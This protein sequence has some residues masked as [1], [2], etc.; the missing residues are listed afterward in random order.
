MKYFNSLPY[1]TTTNVDGNLYA[2]KNLLIR[3]QMIPQLAKNPLLFYEYN[4]QDGD[5][6]EIVAN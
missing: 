2:L 4:L 6:P 3:T 5:T 1:L